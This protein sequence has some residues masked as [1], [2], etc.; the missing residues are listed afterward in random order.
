MPRVDQSFHQFI[1]AETASSGQMKRACAKCGNWIMDR[2]RSKFCK[3]HRRSRNGS[4]QKPVQQSDF[5]NGYYC[6]VA[7]ALR[8][9]GTVTRTVQSMFNQGGSPELANP[10]DVEL[11]R[12]FGL[13]S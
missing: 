1:Q 3:E 6:A 8:E 2:S 5:V 9:E 10:E 12:Q 11:F 13:M 4:G 7:V